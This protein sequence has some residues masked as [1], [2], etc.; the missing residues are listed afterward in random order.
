MI[1]CY[2]SVSNLVLEHL[3]MERNK[4][5]LFFVT[6]MHDKIHKLLGSNWKFS[7]PEDFVLLGTQHSLILS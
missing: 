5:L 3:K 7:A 4:I 6:C 1:S 2:E